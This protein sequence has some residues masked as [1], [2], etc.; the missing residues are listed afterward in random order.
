VPSTARRT[1]NPF[2]NISDSAIRA[3]LVNEVSDSVRLAA[4]KPQTRHH[5]HDANWE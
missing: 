5:G 1:C 4:E 3:L 2:S